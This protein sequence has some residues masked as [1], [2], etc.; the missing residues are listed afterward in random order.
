MKRI[1]F[2]TLHKHFDLTRMADGEGTT[3]RVSFV[4]PGLLIIQ[5]LL[6][7]IPSYTIGT[8]KVLYCD[9]IL[10]LSLVKRADGLNGRQSTLPLTIKDTKIVEPT[11]CQQR[12]MFSHFLKNPTKKTLQNP[13]PLLAG[14]WEERTGCP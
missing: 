14:S 1:I 5:I 3:G 12:A 8:S 11:R 2:L 13:I 4:N 6:T 7:Y 9:N 10:Q